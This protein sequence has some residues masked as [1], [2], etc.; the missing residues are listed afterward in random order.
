LYK[1]AHS[2][3]KQKVRIAS[4][5]FLRPGMSRF[6]RSFNAAPSTACNQ[7]STPILWKRS[8]RFREYTAQMAV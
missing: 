4:F 8:R 7:R 5:G 3:V 1:H 2:S 6:A